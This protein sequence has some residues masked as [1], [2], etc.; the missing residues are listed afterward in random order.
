VYLYFTFVCVF[1]CYVPLYTDVRL[2]HLNKDYFTYLL[3]YLFTILPRTESSNFRS[4]WAQFVELIWN[5]R[6]ISSRVTG[7]HTPAF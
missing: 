1:S 2:S 6:F 3:T 5:Y 4:R 7:F